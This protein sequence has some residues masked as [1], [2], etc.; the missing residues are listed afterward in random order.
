M[1]Y[2]KLALLGCLGAGIVAASSWSSPASAKDSASHISSAIN[3]LNEAARITNR[4]GGTGAVGVVSSADWKVIYSY[5]QQALREAQQADI[6]EM[7]RDYPGFG[8]HFRDELVEGLKLI[9]E[10]GNDPAKAPG[11]L[12]GQFLVQRFGDWFEA[13]E[14]GIRHLK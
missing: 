11:F 14:N 6:S 3:Y 12:K 5:E 2:D 8:D 10:D 9:V 13:N 4:S 7:N 1:A